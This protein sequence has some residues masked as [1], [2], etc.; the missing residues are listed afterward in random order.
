MN[1]RIQFQAPRITQ[2][3]VESI[4]LC[5]EEA[6]D[7]TVTNQ[8]N[9]MRR[10]QTAD[11]RLFAKSGIKLTADEIRFEIDERHEVYGL[12]ISEAELMIAQ[13]DT[14]INRLIHESTD[15]E[16]RTHLANV[17]RCVAIKLQKPAYWN[18]SLD[19]KEKQD[20][21]MNQNPDADIEL[22]SKDKGIVIDAPA[23]LHMVRTNYE[24]HGLNVREAMR[25]TGASIESVEVA[26]HESFNEELQKK[27]ASVPARVIKRMKESINLI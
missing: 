2:L 21:L 9:E 13:S 5:R 19:A 17:P 12:S 27:L 4:D 20:F 3:E 6:R 11:Q 24:Q 16:T 26:I 22:R 15:D 7:S 18:P 25:I 10:D 8:E 14:T 1:S 23:L